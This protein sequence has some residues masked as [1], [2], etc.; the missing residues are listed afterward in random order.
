MSSIDGSGSTNATLPSAPLASAAAST[1]V[2]SAWTAFFTE[3]VGASAALD[4][5]SVEL[6]AGLRVA[7]TNYQQTETHAAESFRGPR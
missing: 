6:A 3:A 1:P 4:E 7:A 5:V 2:A